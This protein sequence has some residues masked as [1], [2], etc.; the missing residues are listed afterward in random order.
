MKSNIHW[1][2]LK[3]NPWLQVNMSS[4]LLLWCFAV[5]P[6]IIGLLS[7]FKGLKYFKSCF[8]DHMNVLRTLLGNQYRFFSLGQSC[9]PLT[10]VRPPWIKRIGLLLFHEELWY[11]IHALMCESSFNP[12]WQLLK[13]R[14]AWLVQNLCF[15]SCSYGGRIVICCFAVLMISIFTFHKVNSMILPWL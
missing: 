7:V 5:W 6:S 8:K 2:L 11:R 9:R 12:P 4:R 1:L 10:T 15:R 13:R 3:S 14:L